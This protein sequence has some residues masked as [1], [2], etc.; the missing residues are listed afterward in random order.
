MWYIGNTHPVLSMMAL[1]CVTVSYA[2]RDTF[3]DR[4]PRFVVVRASPRVLSAATKD[5]S[6]NAKGRFTRSGTTEPAA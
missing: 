6:E 4:S 5:I 2:L 1:V 3:L